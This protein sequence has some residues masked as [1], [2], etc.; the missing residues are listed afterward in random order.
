VLGQVCCEVAL[1]A[2]TRSKLTAR[3]TPSLKLAGWLPCPGSH[4]PTG[5]SGYRATNSAT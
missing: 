5:L 1:F 3:P 2:R 4:S